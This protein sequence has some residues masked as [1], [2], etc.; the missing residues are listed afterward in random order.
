LTN[1]PT[2]SSPWALVCHLRKSPD[3]YN[4]RVKIRSRLLTKAIIL[5]GVAL[6]RVLFKTCRLYA[7]PE[8]PGTNPYETTGENRYLYCVWHDQIVMTVFSGRP[9]NMAGL[10]SGHQDGGYLA[11]AM[12]LLGIVAVRGS[13]KRGGSRAMGELLQRVH[14]YHVAITPDG[15]RGP[16]RKLK[17]G[18][19][20]LASHSGRAIIPSAY[21]CRRGWRI[22]GNWTDM[23]MPWPFTTVHA[24]GGPPFVVPPNLDR[25]QLEQYVERLEKEMQRLQTL[26]DDAAST[27][28]PN[29][30]T[31]LISPTVNSRPQT[32]A[33]A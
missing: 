2:H 30:A 19:V 17:T 28:L 24:R 25:D 18:I 4:L 5:V 20:F 11:D 31:S 23:L 26:V 33:A 3:R 16:R 10:V 22:R 29:P 27:G 21:A 1:K 15:P 6:T 9:K 7:V 32:R 13:S 12:K 14:N 8:R